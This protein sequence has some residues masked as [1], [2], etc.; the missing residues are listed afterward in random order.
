M[1]T[2]KLNTEVLKEGSLEL[3]NLPFKRGAKIKVV[4]T[5]IDKN[6]TLSRLLANTHV[7]SQDDIKEV[8]KGR[9][10]I[11]QWKIS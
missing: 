5:E 8:E 6:R 4:I 10:I 1:M 2:H 9:E 11:N 7:W 3:M